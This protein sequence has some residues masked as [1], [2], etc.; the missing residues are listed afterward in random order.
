M[1]VDVGECGD[2]AAWADLPSSD[3]VFT[4][5]RTVYL[6]P[7]DPPLLVVQPNRWGVIETWF[8]DV[9]CVVECDPVVTSALP[10][11]RIVDGWMDRFHR[12]VD[13]PGRP[14]R[15]EETMRRATR[16]ARTL[17]QLRGVSVAATPFARTIPLI[18]PVRV[19]ELVEEAASHGVVGLRPLDGLGGGVALSV[20]P[21]H[22]DQELA[23]VRQV[24]GGLVA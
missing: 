7:F 11:P 16:F 21:E 18:V 1:T 9:A 24:L 6:E 4:G 19:D 14:A 12:P 5:D 17:C 13:E 20:H 2:H 8:P 23:T 22:T 3:R 15:A 10:L